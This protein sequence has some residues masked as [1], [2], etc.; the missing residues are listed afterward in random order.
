ML[1]CGDREILTDGQGIKTLELYKSLVQTYGKKDVGK[2]NLHS[3][4]KIFLTLNIFIAMFKYK[5]FIVLV[6]KNGRKT[7]IPLMVV[8]NKLFHKKIYH[9]LI[10]STTHQT[11]TENKKYVKIFNSLAGNWS[12]TNTEKKLL[13]ELG[14]RNV[15]VIKN[16]KNLRILKTEELEYSNSE[17]YP[18]C[19]FSRVEELKGIPNIVQAVNR[20]NECYGRTVLTLD[21]YGKVMNQY[22]KEF[23]DLK[24][25]FGDNIHYKGIVDFDKSVETLKQYYMVVFPTK[26]YTEGIPGTLVDAFAAGVP[27]LSAEWESCYD[28]MTD[29][30]GVMYSFNNDTA[31]EESLKYIVENPNNINAMKKECLSE[32]KKYTPN[33]VIKAIDV[34][35]KR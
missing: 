8:F 29:K 18:L 2:I 3:K 27:V 22:E 4:N 33:E 30:V 26:Y 32:A 17:P 7:V 21:I 28:I 25:K 16:F 15:S 14:L 19:T 10:G 34:Y 20:V 9:S 12:E 11:L 13:E 1:V 5:N 24:K 31:L 23:E 6:S 35:L